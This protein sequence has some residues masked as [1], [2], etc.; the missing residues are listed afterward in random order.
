MPPVDSEFGDDVLVFTPE[1]VISKRGQGARLRYL[2][3]YTGFDHCENQWLPKNELV[4]C[5]HLIRA[6]ERR[7]AARQQ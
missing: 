7:E 5:A 4:G 1:R 6:F 3:K 2:V